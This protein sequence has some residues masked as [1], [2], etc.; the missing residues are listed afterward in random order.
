MGMRRREF[1]AA[2]AGVAA[3]RPFA[4]SAERQHRS[5]P[6]LGVISFGNASSPISLR[7]SEEFRRGLRENGY[8]VD[9]NIA[10][11][12][13]FSAD[14]EELRTAVEQLVR[15]N[16]DVILAGGTQAALAAK[17]ATDTIPIVSGAMA[18]P[19]GDGLVAS[20]ARPG[21]NVTGNTFLG[22]ELGPKR[23]QILKETV[24]AATRFAALQHPNVYSERTM[25][26]MVSELE[27][28]ARGLGIGFR[29]FSASR[30]E[31]FEDAFE[32]MT[33]WQAEA[34]LTFPSPMFYARH[35]RL[36]ELA[37]NRRLPTMYVFREAVDAGGLMC[38]GADI[39]DL[40]RLS[41]KYVIKIL[42]GAKP[43]DLPVEQP[44]KFEFVINLKTAKALG[45]TMPP[46]L[47]GIADEVIE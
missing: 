34:L 2:I 33:E 6:L 36:V 32:A 22:P 45:L 1:I 18:D 46:T 28:K 4:V 10:I 11:E 40:S 3:S 24:P 20:L 7:R 31:E 27:E 15:L 23:L 47:L 8:V 9:Q 44:T 43:G 12:E 25:Q 26:S 16:V 19:V 38:Y 5:V 30:P 41:A 17:R 35:K 39:P 42:Q 29:V 37:A 21:G 14:P 13:R